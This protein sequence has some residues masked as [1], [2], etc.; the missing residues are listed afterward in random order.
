VLYCFSNS[1]PYVR[2]P[3]PEG[4]WA[5]RPQYVAGNLESLGSQIHPFY[6]ELASFHG[7]GETATTNLRLQGS[8]KFAKWEIEIMKV[9]RGLVTLRLSGKYMQD[10]EE[11]CICHGT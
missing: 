2:L 3:C 5:L 6:V 4:P 7:V 11:G 1:P 10:Q 9:V 8:M